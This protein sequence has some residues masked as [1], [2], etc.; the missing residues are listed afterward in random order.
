MSAKNWKV[1]DIRFACDGLKLK[2][3]IHLPRAGRHPVV[4]GCHGL[5]SNQNSPK[6][7]ALARACNALGIAYFRFD[8]RGCGRSQGDFEHVT[9][10]AGRCRDLKAAVETIQNLKE[11]GSRMGLFGSS[12]GGTVC[13]SVAAEL[14]VD[15]IVSFAAPLRSHIGKGRP[16]LSNDHDKAAIVLNTDKTAFDISH[17]LAQISNILIIHGEKDE[18][19][20]LEHAHEIYR[21]VS[22]PKKLIVQPNG[23][24][25]MSDENHQHEFICEASRWFKSG[26]VDR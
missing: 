22:T 18:T 20:P 14:Q 6:Q 12:M 8:H 19:V 16:K 3:T 10:L 23:D 2:G 9:S 11:I 4:I 24:H 17:H 15:T 1:K 21:R 5:Y 7:I 25:R 26:L 13:L